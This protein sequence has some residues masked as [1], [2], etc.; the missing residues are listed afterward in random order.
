M[1]S[2]PTNIQY[3][4]AD[5]ISVIADSDFWRRWDTLIDVRMRHLQEHKKLY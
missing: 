4:L 2:V 5:A 1:V 3:Q